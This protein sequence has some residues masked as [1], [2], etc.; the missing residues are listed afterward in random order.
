MES[1]P[2]HNVNAQRYFCLYKIVSL[3]FEDDLGG[4]IFK[5]QRAI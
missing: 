2:N 3:L 5:H 1:N 4:F